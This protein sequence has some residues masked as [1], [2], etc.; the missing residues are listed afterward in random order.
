VCLL[1][2][3]K[4]LYPLTPSRGEQ[5][6]GGLGQPSEPSG[7]PTAAEYIPKRAGTSWPVAIVLL[8][9]GLLVGGAVGYYA[10][11]RPAARNVLTVVGPWAGAEAEAFL[12]VLEAFKAKTGIDVAYTPV[13]QEDLRPLLPIQFAARKAPGDVIFMVSSFIREQGIEGH[14]LEVNDLVNPAN[15]R[16][17]ATT[18]TE[19]L[20]PVTNES[21]GK[22]YGGIYTGKAKPGFWYRQSYFTDNGHAPPTTWPQFLNL[23]EN[24]SNDPGNPTPIVSGGGVGWPL[25]DV[26]EHFLATYGGAAMHRGL[27]NKTVQWTSVPVRTIFEERIV[28]LLGDT[29][30]SPTN[31][32]VDDR[33]SEPLTPDSTAL[34]RWWNK[35]HA[36]YFMG[37]WIGNWLKAL[38]VSSAD[39]N[40]LRVFP[41]PSE[42]GVTSGV[43]FSADY[44]FI[45]AYT[46]R[47]AEARQLF[48]YLLSAEGQTAQVREGGHVATAVGVADDAYPPGDLA[49]AQSLA[50]KVVLVD[51]DDTLGG[52][53]QS[54]FWNQLL[55]LWTSADPWGGL[56]GALTAIQAAT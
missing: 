28:P 2:K 1:A 48:S 34:S 31:P 17:G 54:V 55:G 49:V 7:A 39:L 9:V 37:S 46:T 35:Q 44:M 19:L 32:L 51:L 10:V 6:V 43:V 15:F 12:P 42:S 16:V 13:R 50:G 25:S 14:I 5:G 26:T 27:T 40:D 18:G 24:I 47:L 53:F 3:R 20:A 29:D 8:V 45:P 4:K 23:L 41:L 33:F 22:I 30:P 36:L 21:S 38:D 52:D 11:P 56:G